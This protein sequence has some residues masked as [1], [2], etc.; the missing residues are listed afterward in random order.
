VD[1]SDFVTPISSSNWDDVQLGLDDSSSDG[2]G[3]FLSALDSQSNVS[4]VVSNNNEGLESGSLTGLGLFLDWHDL[5]D[6]I[7]DF[8]SQKVINDLIFLDGESEQVDFF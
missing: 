3:N 1:C 8:S 5:H 7:G 2:S 6:F 4:V